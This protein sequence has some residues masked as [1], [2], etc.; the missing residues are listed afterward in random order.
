VHALRTLHAALRPHGVLLD[1]HPE[2]QHALVEL[3][4]GVQII[5]L[6]QVDETEDIRDITAGRAALGQVIAEGLF[7]A[8]D[9]RTFEFVHHFDSIETWLAYRAERN[10]TGTI[11]EGMLSRG[12]AL[13]AEAPGE[14][15]VR[16]GVRASRYRRA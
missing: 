16:L 7:L 8:E 5:P 2:P 3:R 12:R 11:A 4:R 10:S 14:I 15:C 6:G 1:I 13:L 9:E